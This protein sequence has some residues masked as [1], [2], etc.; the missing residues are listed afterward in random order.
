MKKEKEFVGS[1]FLQWTA[2]IT[3]TYNN[4]N[5]GP[6]DSNQLLFTAAWGKTAAGNLTPAANNSSLTRVFDLVTIDG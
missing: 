5:C 3:H 2:I 6:V 1:V 4:N